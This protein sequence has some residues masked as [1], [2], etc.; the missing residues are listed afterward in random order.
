MNTYISWN[1]KSLNLYI[2]FT[3]FHT[4]FL[5]KFRI[6][7]DFAFLINKNQF[8]NFKETKTFISN[9]SKSLSGF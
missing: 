8:D 1:F 6:S 9:L 2:N 4:L 3:I 5:S 7:S